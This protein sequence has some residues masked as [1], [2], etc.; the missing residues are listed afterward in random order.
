MINC[1]W[2]RVSD[3]F[4]FIE[5]KLIIHYKSQYNFVWSIF[6]N[7]FIIL[8]YIY[9]WTFI[10][11][12][13][14]VPFIIMYSNTIHPPSLYVRSVRDLSPP[15]QFHWNLW[16]NQSIYIFKDNAEFNKLR[17][18]W[19]NSMREDFISLLKLHRVIDV[20]LTFNT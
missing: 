8:L 17:T 19:R 1:P 12:Q 4:Y 15:K 14:V 13:W 9:L 6:V 20:R 5:G 16:K 3:H 11:Y 2:E 7:S 18:N 10:E